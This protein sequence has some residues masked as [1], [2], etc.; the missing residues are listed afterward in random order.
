MFSRKQL[1]ILAFPNSKY[2]ALICD[3]AIRTGK[4]SIMA[5]SFLTWAMRDFNGVNFGICSKTLQTADRN[6]IKPLM[7]MTYIKE[8]FVIKYHTY[9]YLEVRAFGH[10]NTFY[11]YGGRDASSY[12]LIQ[13]IT[14]AGVFL[15]EVALMPRSFVEQA[16]ARCSVSG[17]R[18]WFNC[19]PEGQMHWFNQEWVLNCEEHNA[20]HLHFTLDDNPAL[21]ED[22]KRDYE[23]M[24][25]GV[26]HDRY[27]KG[28][29]VNA[30]G[31]IFDSFDK[32]KHILSEEQIETIE[33]EDAPIV[34]SD[35]GIQNATVF[36]YYRK[37]KGKNVWVAVDEYYYSG[38]D[39]RKQK[40]VT[41]LVDAL[42]ELVK[43]NSPRDKQGNVI[44]LMPKIVIIDPSAS[45]LIVEARKRGF[46]TREG[47]N[48]VI[49]GIADVQKMLNESRLLFSDRC[50]HTTEE[51][52]MYAWDEKASERGEDRPIKENDHCMDAN[53]YFVYTLKLARKSLEDRAPNN[54]MYL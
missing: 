34:S 24:Y 41:E 45:A 18:F 31:I 44:S 25:S 53:R 54:L 48:D 17:R 47:N 35:F 21:P 43:R 50:K 51:F 9:S 42:E 23:N 16:L 27:I 6:V 32:D 33:F 36:L 39:E 26:F 3:G 49:N 40:T 28:L 22:I 11:M 52:G 7:A 1:Q 4:T 37:I 19:N 15:D 20:L 30:E 5:V 14:L 2:T 10:T 8:R 13:G 46:K 29:W 38:R 12:Q